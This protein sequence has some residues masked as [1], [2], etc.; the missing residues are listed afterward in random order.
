MN[1]IFQ[2]IRCEK[3]RKKIGELKEGIGRYWCGDC[4]L[5]QIVKIDPVP[6]GTKPFQERIPMARKGN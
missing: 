4:K 1:E 6:P 5:V 3:C 2:T